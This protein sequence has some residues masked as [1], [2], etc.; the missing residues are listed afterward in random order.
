MSLKG[1]DSPPLWVHLIIWFRND[2]PNSEE[3]LLFGIVFEQ[4]RFSTYHRLSSNLLPAS[5]FLHFTQ[6]MISLS[7]HCRS[8]HVTRTGSNSLAM[9]DQV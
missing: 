9:S 8:V 4:T 5:S 1:L 2:K 3:L 6:C 7:C